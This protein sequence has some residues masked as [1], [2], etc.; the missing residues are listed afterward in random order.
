MGS[1]AGWAPCSPPPPC[2]WARPWR[3]RAAACSTRCSMH[4]LWHWIV[5]H[6]TSR[7]PRWWRCAASAGNR[8]VP[9]TP[10]ATRPRHLLRTHRVLDCGTSLLGLQASSMAVRILSL[11]DLL[12]C[13]GRS[14]IWH[15]RIEIIHSPRVSRWRIGAAPGSA[16]PIEV[17]TANRRPLFALRDLGARVKVRAAGLVSC[18]QDL[19]KPLLNCT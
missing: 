19:T 4:C 7:R 9:P 12:L 14:G 6:W 11:R 2:C 17:Y 5:A 15:R 1:T 13:I 18:T 8:C 16:S 10:P 3:R